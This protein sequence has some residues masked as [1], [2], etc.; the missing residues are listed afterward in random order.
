[1]ELE[2]VEMERLDSIGISPEQLKALRFASVGSGAEGVSLSFEGEGGDVEEGGSG[3][4]GEDDSLTLSTHSDGSEETTPP[5]SEAPP[6]PPLGNQ[7]RVEP[8]AEPEA[9]ELAV[10]PPLSPP[11]SRSESR[12]GRVDSAEEIARRSSV[13]WLFQ[14]DDD[15]D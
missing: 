11:L 13:N 7:V 1:V 6:T 15:S 9:A 4:E 14:G 5:G 2:K 10:E 3:E 12:S 8:A